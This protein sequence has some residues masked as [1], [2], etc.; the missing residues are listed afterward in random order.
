MLLGNDAAAAEHF[1]RT[2]KLDSDPEVVE[3]AWYQLGT[4]Y[5]RL[6]R[7]DEARLAMETFQKLKDQ[8]AENSQMRLKKY[9]A[10]KNLVGASPAAGKEEPK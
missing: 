5:R 6:H 7:V 4:A 8:E 3:Q 2:T 1:E 9:Q 10:D